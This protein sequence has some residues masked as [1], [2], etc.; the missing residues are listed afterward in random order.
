MQEITFDELST[1]NQPSASLRTALDKI[2]AALGSV[3]D[4]GQQARSVV[5][6]LRVSLR[7]AAAQSVKSARSLAKFDEINRL[8]APAEDKTAAPE[9]QKKA[10]EAAAKAEEAARSTTGTAARRSGTAGSDLSGLTAVWQS[11]LE[12][13]RGAWA[14]F[15]AYLQEFFAPFAAAWQTVW[16]GLSAAAAGVWEQ[17]CAAL[18]TVVQPALAL[19]DTVWQGLWAGMEQ[20]WAAYG[21]PILDGLAQGWQNVVGIVSALWSEVLQPVLVQLF[22][23]LGA[24]WTAHLQ[25]LWNELT[26]CLGAVTTLLLTLWN[27]V[28]APFVQWLITALAPV[29][30][31]VFAA[32]GT[33]VTGAAG[34]IADGITIALAVL[35]GMAD[36]LTAVLRGEW[37][38]AWAAMAGTV[39]TVWGRIVSIV[40]TA[41]STVLGVVRSMVAAIAAAINGLLSAIGHAK[42]MAGSVLGGAGKLVSSQSA[43]LGL[44]YAASVPVPALAQGAVIPPNRQF[45]AMLGDQTTGTNVEAPLATIK[46]AMAETLAG[47]QGSADGQPINIYIGEE[48]L[49]SVIANSQN[50]RALRSG[51]RGSVE[52]LNID[53]TALPAPSAYKVQLSDLDSNGTGRT[54]DGVLV[55]ERVRGGVA[56]ISAG[57]AALSTADCAKV[58]NAT[59]PDSMTVQY[60]FGGVRTAKMYAGD[61]TADLKAARDGQAVWE[62]AVN[63]IEF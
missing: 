55:R 30:V 16:Q 26:A 39:S 53:G 9:K 37:D 22:D 1:L 32:L 20:A 8:S 17:L 4:A 34:I 63:L 23:L 59:A 27:T 35:R 42:S 13:L 57:W 41:V 43:L 33:A 3:G 40:Q 45:L 6:E 46:Q 54:E 14:D 52:I 61:R 24:L 12:S 62:V 44:G 15:W 56:K 60:F 38:A 47:W 2:S 31:Q 21:Q 28:L 19:L 50:R 36:F 58:L 11:V 7:A 25:P 48:L 18:S 10:A 29:A 51:G 49:D 5:D